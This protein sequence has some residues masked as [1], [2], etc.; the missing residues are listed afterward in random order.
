MTGAKILEFERKEVRERRLREE[1]RA[2]DFIKWDYTNASGLPADPQDL[3][4]PV[5][6]HAGKE[7]L[8]QMLWPLLTV[9]TGKVEITITELNQADKYT[10][11]RIDDNGI[12]HFYREE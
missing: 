9:A 12:L 5:I 10:L 7:V 6:L 4:V 2:K 11:K 1:K 8:E 3:K